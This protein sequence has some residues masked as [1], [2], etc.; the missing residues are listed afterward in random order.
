VKRLLP[1][2]TRLEL[3]QLHRGEKHRARLQAQFLARLFSVPSLVTLSKPQQAELL[4]EARRSG[5]SCTESVDQLLWPILTHVHG[6][7]FPL[8]NSLLNGQ[9]TSLQPLGERERARLLL[10][11]KS[12]RVLD[13]RSTE[14][15]DEEMLL[16]LWSLLRNRKGAFPFQ[17]CPHCQT[18]VFF[19]FGTRK[20]CSRECT[21]QA[22]EAA[23][24]GTRNEYMRVLMAKKRARAKARGKGNS[25]RP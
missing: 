6:I 3:A 14:Y 5:F 23:R 25:H 21:N 22:N 15:L 4:K 20:Y 12:G 24:R 8:M 17:R 16:S 19:V 11:P 7:A 18:G 9:E 13:I 2:D 1:K 10:I